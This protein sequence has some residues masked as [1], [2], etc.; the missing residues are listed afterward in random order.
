MSLPSSRE[1]FSTVPGYTGVVSCS[2]FSNFGLG[3][4]TAHD[5]LCCIVCDPKD[6]ITLKVST[7]AVHVRKHFPSKTIYERDILA[8][9][10]R[11][12]VYHGEVS[13][14]SPGFLVK[15]T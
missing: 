13:L 3:V 7:C 9:C 4:T 15:L 1:R 8:L 14:C 2:S 10:A 12:N 6:L 5:I 11:Y